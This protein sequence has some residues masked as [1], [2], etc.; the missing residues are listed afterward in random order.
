MDS[1][2]I[3]RSLAVGEPFTGEETYLG[4][5]RR[6]TIVVS[7]QV[8]C[9]E[10]FY[11]PDCGTLCVPQDSSR[12]H[13]TCNSQGNRVCFD[14]YQDPTSNCTQCLPS[15]G[16]CKLILDHVNPSASCIYSLKG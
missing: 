11:G 16:C 6:G 14:G 4:E 13:Y 12:G 3:T 9:T 10:N 2:T 15:E 5:N 1:I 8:V 7:F